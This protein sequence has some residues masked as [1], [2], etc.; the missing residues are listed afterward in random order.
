MNKV[1]RFREAL[2]MSKAQ[3]SKMMGFKPWRLI[4][5]PVKNEGTNMPSTCH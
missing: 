3:P 1:Q 4:K 2:M 5:W